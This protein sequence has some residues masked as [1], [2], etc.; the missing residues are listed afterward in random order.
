L[1]EFFSGALIPLAMFPQALRA[2]AFYTPFPYML[3]IPVSVLLGGQ[4]P[5]GYTWLLAIQVAFIAVFMLL[6]HLIYRK[7]SKNMVI[8]GG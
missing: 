1:Y 8:A 4:L 6:H 2:F 3:N 7:L 5:M